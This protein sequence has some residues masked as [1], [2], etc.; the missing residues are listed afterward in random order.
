MAQVKALI[1]N[2]KGKDGEDG[3]ENQIY[4]Y[5][6]TPIGTW[7]NGKPLY[8]KII[9][10]SVNQGVQKIYDVSNMNLDDIIRMDGSISQSVGSIVH[11]PYG[12][13]SNDF[14]VIYYPKSSNQIEINTTRAGIVN[15]IL[16]Y[17]KTT[18]TATT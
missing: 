12:T 4:S 1:G 13:G 17:T 6:E 2:I 15:I 3:S 18:D 14:A 7:V 11:I 9:K 10:T 5:D 8:R 16:E